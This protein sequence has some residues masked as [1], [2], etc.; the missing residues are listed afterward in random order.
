MKK[1]HAIY[2]LNIALLEIQAERIFLCCVMK[3]IEGFSLSLRDGGDVGTPFLFPV[4]SE[5]TTR[6]LDD[7]VAIVIVE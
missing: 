7:N 5:V 1:P 4:S 3:R 2:I 6:I